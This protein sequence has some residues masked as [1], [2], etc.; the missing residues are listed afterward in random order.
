MQKDEQQK[1]LG[2]VET[3]LLAQAA[4]VPK[5]RVELVDRF[6]EARSKIVREF[7]AAQT[8]PL[9]TGAFVG[10]GFAAG[11]QIVNVVAGV[12]TFAVSGTLT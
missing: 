1:Y 9:P 3:I 11:G 6:V 12:L 8:W 2:E 10:I 4:A 7:A 5:D